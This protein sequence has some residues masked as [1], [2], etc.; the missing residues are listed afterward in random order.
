MTKE[1]ILSI[2]NERERLKAIEANIGLFQKK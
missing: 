1:Q 2:K